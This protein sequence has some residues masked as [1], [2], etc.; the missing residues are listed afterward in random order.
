M[1]RYTDFS[2]EQ[3]AAL[4]KEDDEQAFSE[5]YNRYWPVLWRFAANSM[6]SRDDAKDIIQDVFTKLWSGRRNLAI[7]TALRP[8]LYRMTLHAVIDN[9]AKAKDFEGFADALRREMHAGVN[10]TEQLIYEKELIR[11]FESGLDRVPPKARKVFELSRTYQMSHQQISSELDI[12][13]ETVKSQMKVAL[14]ILRKSLSLLAALLIS[15]L[16]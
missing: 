15:D 10:T 4:L 9:A 11:C 14:K 8:Y 6:K 1:N 3:L 5:L 12:S 13:R 16:F 2:D 7:H